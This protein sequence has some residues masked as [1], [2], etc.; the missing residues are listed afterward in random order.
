LLT[1]KITDEKK[2]LPYPMQLSVFTIS[3]VMPSQTKQQYKTSSIGDIP[4]SSFMGYASIVEMVVS[5]N[6][7]WTLV[8]GRRGRHEGVTVPVYPA[9][10]LRHLITCSY[11]KKDGNI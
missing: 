7:V 5:G 11:F 10:R 6:T 3:T 8:K 2:T 4:R 9:T 1:G